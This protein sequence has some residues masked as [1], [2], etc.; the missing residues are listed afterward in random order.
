M[1]SSEAWDPTFKVNGCSI[2]T[3]PMSHCPVRHIFFDI[4]R[5]FCG[6]PK[7]PRFFLSPKLKTVYKG[8]HFG[9]LE[10]IWKS[11]TD[12]LNS[13]PNK[14]F[15]HCWKHRLQRYFAV[16]GNYFEG[17][18]IDVRK[19]KT[20]PRTF[21]GVSKYYITNQVMSLHSPYS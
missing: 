3:T 5:H 13:I 14:E 4:Q 2:T 7:S 20:T 6:S 16:H 12:K 18:D 8:R 11:L 15:Q 21:R 19:N 17:D 9:T 10:N 1:R